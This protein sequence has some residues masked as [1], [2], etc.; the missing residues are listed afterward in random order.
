VPLG[1][2]LLGVALGPSST[3]TRRLRVHPVFGRGILAAL[4]PSRGRPGRAD[5]VYDNRIFI[6]G[7][8]T[9]AIVA[10]ILTSSATAPAST[11]PVVLITFGLRIFNNVLIRRHFARAAQRGRTT[12]VEREAVLVAIDVG[13]SGLHPDREVSRDGRMTVMGRRTV[14][15]SGLKKGGTSTRPSARSPSPSS[16]PSGSGKDRPGLRSVGG[17]HVESPN[18]PGQV[19]VS[20]PREVSREDVNRAVEVARAV[21]IPSNQVVLHVERRGFTVDGQ[22]GVKDPSGCALRLEVQVHIV[23]AAATAVQNWRR[24]AGRVKIDEPWRRP[25]RRPT[26]PSETVKESGPS[27]TWARARSTCPVRR[28]PSFRTAVLPIGGNNVT[29]DVALG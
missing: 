5:G 15:S 23:T 7:F 10:V 13:T 25:W 2:L 28:R 24:N 19:A 17:Q 16:A 12:N 18:S 8:I 1:G 11:S 22:E 29:N 26:C 3:S 20:G 21:S 4:D 9:N 14:P 27:P 6:S